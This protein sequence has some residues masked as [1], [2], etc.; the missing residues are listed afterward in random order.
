MHLPVTDRISLTEFRPSDKATCVERIGGRE[1]YDRT[2][3]IPHPYTEAHFDQWLNIVAEATEQHGQPIH[4]VI[5]E[6]DSL[7][8]SVGFDGL[9][10]ATR[11]RSGIGSPSRGGAGGS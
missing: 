10:K 11:P 9:T 3:R 7:I 6:G 4:F 1:I 5:R 8:G 2:L